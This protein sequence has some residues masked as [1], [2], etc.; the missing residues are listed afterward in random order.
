ME[1][2]LSKDQ[3]AALWCLRFAIKELRYAVRNKQ[4]L[5]WW[6]SDI[7]YDDG[8]REYSAFKGLAPTVLRILIEPR[9][10]NT[11]PSKKDRVNAHEEIAGNGRVFTNT[12]RFTAVMDE[13][14]E[15]RIEDQK[16]GI[17]VGQELPDPWVLLA[18]QLAK[19]DFY[20][21]PDTKVPWWK[22]F[23]QSSVPEGQDVSA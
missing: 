12:P 4:R 5:K 9:R 23:R 3:R 19:A 2:K 21:T 16:K 14:K 7:H 6:R 13:E 20:C 18:E 8:F 15:K 17:H 10:Q 22:L 11:L 1:Y